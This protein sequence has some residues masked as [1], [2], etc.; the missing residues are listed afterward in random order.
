MDDT[1]TQK[2]DPEAQARFEW[3][4]G[5][6]QGAGTIALLA[7]NFDGEPTTAIVSVARDGDEYILSPLYVAVT[8]TMADKMR[9][10]MGALPDAVQS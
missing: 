9:D 7:V 1:L 8:S 5:G 3:L 2:I 10:P 6:R 4:T